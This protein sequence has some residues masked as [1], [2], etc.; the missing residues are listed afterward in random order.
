MY[1]NESKYEFNESTGKWD[2]LYRGFDYI[3]FNNHN[4]KVVK[5]VDSEDEAK[6]VS[7]NCVSFED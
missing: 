3:T 4:W 1:K 2:V 7:E 5:S 6:V